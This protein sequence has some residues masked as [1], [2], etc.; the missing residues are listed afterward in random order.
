[1]AEFNEIMAH[2]TKILAD[3]GLKPW[4]PAHKRIQQDWSKWHIIIDGKKY[5]S[6]FENFYDWQAFYGRN[7]E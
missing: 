2:G 7:H 5:Y 4:K 3:A 6:K 1:M